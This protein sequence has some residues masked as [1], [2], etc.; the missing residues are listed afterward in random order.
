MS[1]APLHLDEAVTTLEYITL[2][3]Q[4]LALSS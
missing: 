4:F 1:G 3:F 2:G